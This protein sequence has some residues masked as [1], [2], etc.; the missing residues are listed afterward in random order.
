MPRRTRTSDVGDVQDAAADRGGS[1][2]DNLAAFAGRIMAVPKS[3]LPKRD[4][5]LKRRRRKRR[6]RA[7][8]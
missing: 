4:K 7:G 1:T 5:K 3:E 8:G 6:Q 2:L